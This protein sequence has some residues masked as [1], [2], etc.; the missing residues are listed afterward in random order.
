MKKGYW[1]VA[2]RSIL[3][4][5]AVKAYSALAAPAIQASGGRL[6]TNS[7]LGGCL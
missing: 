3:D 1:V 5:A 2:Y 6:L 4:E 7:A